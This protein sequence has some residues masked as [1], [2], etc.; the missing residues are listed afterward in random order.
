MDSGSVFN[1]PPL[2]SSN[3]V[4]SS[5]DSLPFISSDEVAQSLETFNSSFDESQVNWDS[6]E[7]L[8]NLV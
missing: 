3:K 5:H 7:P 4:V 2:F 8:F 6:L 1:I